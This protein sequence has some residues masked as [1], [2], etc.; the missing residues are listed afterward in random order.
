MQ[1]SLCIY[2]P[3]YNYARYLPGAVKSLLKQTYKDFELIIVDDC[4]TDNSWDIIQRLARLDRR[5][6]AY[7]TKRN[8]GQYAIGNL[9]ARMTEAKYFSC[10]DAD[11]ISLPNRLATQMRFL[12]G[13]PDVDFVGTKIIKWRDGRTIDK[14]WPLDCD[15]Y[16]TLPKENCFAHSSVIMKR[17]AFLS[18]GGYRG[19]NNTFA[20]CDYLLWFTLLLHGYRGVNLN[21]RLVVIC[22]HANHVGQRYQPPDREFLPYLSLLAPQLKK[23][24]EYS[25]KRAYDVLERVKRIPGFLFDKEALDLY[26]LAFSAVGVGEIVE[27]GASVGR[28]TTAIAYGCKH[29]GTGKV[30]TIDS[31]AW[32]TV[33]DIE[34]SEQQ[35]RRNTAR[36]KDYIQLHVAASEEIG[37]GWNRPIKMIFIDGDH[38][39]EAVRRDIELFLPHIVPGGV[40]AFHDYHNAE[41]GGVQRAVEEVKDKLVFKTQSHKRGMLYGYK[42]AT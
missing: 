25:K 12:K 36:L 11:D 30:T 28:A 42:K 39:Y 17:E 1:P 7:R 20:G 37:K 10:H 32:K 34:N 35:F 41:F 19:D 26:R 16:S 15:V 3:N 24:S 5:I 21:N 2:M 4:S 6:R 31:Y 9:C 33:K 27:I 13:N 40:V 8:I 23:M 18:V 22:R 29:G 14:E 38:S